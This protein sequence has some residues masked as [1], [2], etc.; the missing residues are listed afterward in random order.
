MRSVA[1]SSAGR[2]TTSTR[3]AMNVL[4]ASA[5][6]T[7]N[8]QPWI[9]CRVGIQLDRMTDL[10]DKAVAIDIGGEGLDKD[11]AERCSIRRAGPQHQ[12]KILGGPGPQAQTELKRGTAL[13][14]P[15]L[16]GGRE[17]G[18]DPVE[19]HDAAQPPVVDALCLGVAL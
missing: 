13:E 11:L 4:P 14:H 19:D 12:V 10:E 15:A 2:S 18:G 9:A 3:T 17:P 8:R 5:P 7:E 6:S 16:I 1:A